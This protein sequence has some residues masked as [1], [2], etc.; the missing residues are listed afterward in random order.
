MRGGLVFAACVNIRSACRVSANSA[1]D[2]AVAP[3]ATSGCQ[4]RSGGQG[5]HLVIGAD[6]SR[7]FVVAVPFSAMAVGIQRH[8]RPVGCT[9]TPWLEIESR[10]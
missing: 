9:V 5:V 7:R 2:I 1:E 3:H 6:G 10:Y 8:E 4:G